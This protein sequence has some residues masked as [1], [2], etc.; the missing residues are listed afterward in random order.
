MFWISFLFCSSLHW[1]SYQYFSFWSFNHARKAP[2]IVKHT[3]DLQMQASLCAPAL[4]LRQCD[5]SVEKNVLIFREF[6]ISFNSS[7]SSEYRDD[8]TK[9]GA[10][11]PLSP[12][13]PGCTDRYQHGAAAGAG[14]NCRTAS[15]PFTDSCLTH[16]FLIWLASGA[17]PAPDS[18][19]VMIKAAKSPWQT[20][21]WAFLTTETQHYHSDVSPCFK[22]FDFLAKFDSHHF[23]R[24]MVLCV[25][26]GNVHMGSASSKTKRL[27]GT[28]SCGCFCKTMYIVAEIKTG[29]QA[30]P[31]RSTYWGSNIF[32]HWWKSRPEIFVLVKIWLAAF[33]LWI[34]DSSGAARG[35]QFCFMTDFWFCCAVSP[36]R[37]TFFFFSPPVECSLVKTCSGI[38]ILS[39]SATS[40]PGSYLRKLLVA[41]IID[42]N[43]MSSRS[44]FGE[45]VSFPFKARKL[46]WLL[47]LYLNLK[48]QYA[49]LSLTYP[50]ACTTV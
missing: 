13:W 35:W 25:I 48:F 21:N 23:G 12:R 37:I 11:L 18:W 17:W 4:F 41:K 27:A 20:P 6:S 9:V 44:I 36:G 3:I 42:A 24:T 34:C 39:I 30:R 46:Y 8:D 5:V 7:R 40:L 14:M 33:T 49:D 31:D 22:S 19:S 28:Y 16:F 50:F 10:H 26:A 2:N 43:S 38:F 47:I 29:F 1:L 15:L 32:G 45:M